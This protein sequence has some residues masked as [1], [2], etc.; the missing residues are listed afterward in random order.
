LVQHLSMIAKVHGHLNVEPL[1]GA[2]SS[3]MHMLQIERSVRSQSFL[4]NLLKKRKKHGFGLWDRQR[5]Q[6]PTTIDRT[7]SREDWPAE[8]SGR[9]ETWVLEPPAPVGQRS[10]ELKS[11]IV[12]RLYFV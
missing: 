6:V 3:R 9:G 12:P 2:L 8:K 10:I 4:L 5:S 7:E 1:E 11:E